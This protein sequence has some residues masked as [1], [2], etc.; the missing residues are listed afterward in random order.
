MF[1]Q[2][3]ELPPALR[4]YSL[5]ALWRK[6]QGLKGLSLIG[7]HRAL[8]REDARK[9]RL[10]AL[11]WPRDQLWAGGLLKRPLRCLKLGLPLSGIPCWYTVPV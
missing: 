7:L 2:A 8:L 9:Q 1:L 4:T 6:Y 5:L 11:R 3:E 10:Q